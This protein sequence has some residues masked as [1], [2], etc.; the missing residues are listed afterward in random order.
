MSNPEQE[1]KENPHDFTKG[2]T[3]IQC[4]YTTKHLQGSAKKIDL[5]TEVVRAHQQSREKNNGGYGNADFE[6]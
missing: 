4:A 2:K 1:R 5:R 6:R 3:S